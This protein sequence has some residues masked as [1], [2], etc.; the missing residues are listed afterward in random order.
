VHDDAVA[1]ADPELVQSAR[2]AADLRREL[3]VGQLGDRP[4]A[5]LEDEEGAIAA[6]DGALLEHV[7]EVALSARVEHQ[8][9]NIPPLTSSVTPWT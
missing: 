5:V 6:R 8:A 2:A 4:F 7:G 9:M 1:A 3:V